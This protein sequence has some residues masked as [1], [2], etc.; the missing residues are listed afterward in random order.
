MYQVDNEKFGAFITQLRKEKNFTQKELGERLFVSD[1]AIS[2]WERGLSMPN[3]SLLVPMADILGVTVTELLRGEHMYAEERL[4]RDEVEE[5]VTS[6]MDMTLK[7]QEAETRRRKKWLWVYGG[8]A[9]AVGVECMVMWKMNLI[10]DNF[11]S[12]LV[13]EGMLLFFCAWACIFA[14]ETLPSY[15]DEHKIHF[16]SDG[17]FRVNMPGIFF[18]NSNWPH[19]LNWFRIVLMGLGIGYPLLS[20]GL[21]GMAVSLWWVLPIL[22]FV[23]APLYYI[24]KKYA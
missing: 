16:V 23:F 19:I 9:A 1:K 15:Y 2:K 6:S 17:V 18:N 5:L 8:M 7:I 11:T 22:L 13:T 14:R 4:D 12:L 21:G 3:I 20:I 24:A 10:N